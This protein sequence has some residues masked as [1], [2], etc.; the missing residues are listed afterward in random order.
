MGEATPARSLCTS[1]NRHRLRC[2]KISSVLRGVG[3]RGVK[4]IPLI[5]PRSTHG[6]VG[7]YTDRQT[8]DG[9]VS[10]SRKQHKKGTLSLYVAGEGAQEGSGPG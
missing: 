9:V 6:L 5:C 8:G 3:D 10:A 4:E 7:M 2:T 1:V